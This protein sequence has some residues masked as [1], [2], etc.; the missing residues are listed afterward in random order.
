VVDLLCDGLTNRQIGERLFVSTRTVDTHVMH[1]FRK[2]G[3]R[4]RTE[5]V[6]AAA[7]RNAGT[8]NP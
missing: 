6:S 1:L 5:L 8:E 3:V 2:L 7:R 4:S